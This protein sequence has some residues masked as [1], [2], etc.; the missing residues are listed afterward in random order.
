MTRDEPTS[1]QV[2]AIE[3][4]GRA[5]ADRGLDLERLARSM[6]AVS[7]ESDAT[8][9]IGGPP[10]RPDDV[11]ALNMNLV[12][13]GR[14]GC[15]ALQSLVAQ[16]TLMAYLGEADASLTLALPG[17]GLAMPP[18]VALASVKQREQFLR[19]F[20]SDAPRWGAFTITEPD[21]GSDA[22][23]MRTSARKTG[24]GWVLNGTKCFITNGAR[25]NCVI[26]FATI[27]R[28]MGHYGTGWA[29]S[30]APRCLKRT[31]HPTSI[32]TT[33]SGTCCSRRIL[34]VSDTS[35]SPI[36]H[37]SRPVLWP[38]A[39]QAAPA[40]CSG[41]RRVFSSVAVS[42]AYRLG[43]ASSTCPNRTIGMV[44]IPY[45]NHRAAICRL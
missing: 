40:L 19:R 3:Y 20:E 35:P 39:G 24:R 37:R 9:K 25:A 10:W 26:T 11:R 29:A 32:S 36:G 33:K 7:S 1:Q 27:N 13:A 30:W 43:P 8:G 41:R 5:L 14:G 28:Q 23:A 45:M 12:P 42:L 44:V 2:H 22:T 38:G 16:A 34:P 6:R 15:P 18:V 4:I 21:C 31:A 17:P